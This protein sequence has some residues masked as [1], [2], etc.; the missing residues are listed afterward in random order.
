MI[1]RVGLVSMELSDDH[2][3]YVYLGALKAY[4]VRPLWSKHLKVESWS[5]GVKLE[6]KGKVGGYNVRLSFGERL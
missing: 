3:L 4:L 1:K 2:L 6:V 5:K